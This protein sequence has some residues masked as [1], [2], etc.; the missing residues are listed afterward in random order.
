MT[1][2]NVVDLLQELTRSRSAACGNT[3][4]IGIDGRS[5][6]GKTALASHLASECDWPT[7]SLENLYPG[8]HGLGTGISRAAACLADFAIGEHHE[9]P[10]WDW[11][12]SRPGP[13][14]TVLPRPFL[15]LEGVGAGAR[16]I[17]PFL[18]VLIWLDAPDELRKKRALARDGETFEPWWD[19]WRAQEDDYFV[20]DQPRAHADL[21]INTA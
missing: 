12:A 20:T 6:S 14:K 4:V 21:L 1:T 19:T 11:Y 3:F 9:L 17:R 8:W 7:L 13:S 18:S 16:N 2:S 5:G 15:V 10:Q